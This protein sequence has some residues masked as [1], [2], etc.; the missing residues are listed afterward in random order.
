MSQGGCPWKNMFYGCYL[1]HSTAITHNIYT[2]DKLLQDSCDIGSVLYIVLSALEFLAESVWLLSHTLP[3]PTFSA[4]RFST[5]LMLTL[6]GRRWHDSKMFS[7][8]IWLIQIAW[9]WKHFQQFCSCRTCCVILQGN[10]F[11]G[12]CV[13]HTFNSVNADYKYKTSIIFLHCIN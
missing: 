9:F 12:D 13:E 3:P 6:K 1:D 7:G 2:C 5:L 8:S 11:R 4:M 10:H